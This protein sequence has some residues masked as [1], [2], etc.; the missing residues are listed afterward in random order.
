[1]KHREGFTLGEFLRARRERMT[2]EEA[3]L[4]SYGRRRT[5]GLRREE[6][7]QLAHI[8]TSWYISLEQGR[9]TN[10]S[11]QVLDSLARVFKLSAEERLHLF[12]LARPP[13]P[14][15]DDAD[16]SVGLQRTVMALDPNP[17]LVMRK[18]WDLLLWNR[19]AELVFRLP[20]H[21]AAQEKPNWLKRFL[22]DPSVRANSADWEMKAQVMIARF[23][24]DYA[25]YPQDPAIHA[26]I[27][28]LAE[29]SEWFRLH[30]NRH[31]ISPPADCHKLWDIPGIG[32]LEFEYVALN[33]AMNKHLQLMVYTAAPGTAKLL[34]ERLS[35][36]GGE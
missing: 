15:E 19:A 31:D 36:S 17:A 27:G 8:G 9:E 6:V 1:M 7:A 5:P 11:D 16:I 22:I 28:E 21:S 18:S 23:R 35:L 12:R 3:G 32:R 24:A 20:A 30:W 10:P 14:V 2:P 25:R 13:A 4:P 33:P 26:L 29:T 34:H